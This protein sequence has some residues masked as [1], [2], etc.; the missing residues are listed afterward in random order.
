MPVRRSQSTSLRSWHVLCQDCARAPLSASGRFPVRRGFG[1][2]AR[3]W[4]HSGRRPGPARGPGQRGDR[5]PRRSGLPDVPGRQ[6]L[7]HRHLQ[8]PR[9]LAQRRLA[10]QHGRIDHLPAPRLRP[11]PRRLPLRHPVRDRHQRPQDRQGHVPVRQPEQPGAVSAWPRHPDR[12]RQDAL[13][14]TTGMR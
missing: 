5:R 12:G 9:R 2:C 6:H 14:D 1:G 3:R 4:R 13:G 10:A 11:G 8:A 7:E